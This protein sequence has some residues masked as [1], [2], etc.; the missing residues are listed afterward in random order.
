[1]QT[2]L[3]A[4]HEFLPENALWAQPQ[5][6]YT[7]WVRMPKKVSAAS[8]NAYLSEKGLRVSSGGYFFPRQC[9]SEYLRLSIARIDEA[10]IWEGMARLG[11][12][13][14][15]LPGRIP[16]KRTVLPLSK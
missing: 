10:Q 5:G 1:M 12:A 3:R 6:G 7:I 16:D 2:A 9:P 14:R 11:Q 15:E 8:L 4:I 13:L